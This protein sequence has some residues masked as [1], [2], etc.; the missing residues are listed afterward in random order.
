MNIVSTRLPGVLLVDC[1]VHRDERGFFVEV[2]RQDQFRRA[3]VDHPFVQDGHSRSGRGVI[4]GLHFQR[5]YPQAKLIHVARGRV[6]DVVVDVRAGSPTF[7]HWLAEELGEGEGRHLYIPRGYAHGFQVLSETADV[8]YKCSAFYRPDDEGGVRWDDPDIG[9]SW[10]IPDPVL[11]QKDRGL[12]RLNEIDP[13]LLPR[14]E[15]TP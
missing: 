15:P 3:G 9:I 1:P 8:V 7:G 14:Y 4:R 11:S 12:G 2:F 6:Y 5:L 13:D 10:P